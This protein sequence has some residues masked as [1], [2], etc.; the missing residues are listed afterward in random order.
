L[1]KLKE[2]S[3]VSRLGA[4]PVAAVRHRSLFQRYLPAVARGSSGVS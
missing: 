4:A 2:S 3:F 1:M